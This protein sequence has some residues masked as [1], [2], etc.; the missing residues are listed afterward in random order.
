[1]E[2]ATPFKEVIE[3]IKEN[4]GEA[5]K[6]CYQCG[7]CDTVCPWNRVRTF[8]MRK[9]IREAAFGLTEIE[10]EEIW[11]CTT[12]GKCAQRCPR[13][14]KQIQNMV[15]LRRMATG[16]GVFPGAVKPVR[17]ASAG[18][19]GEGNPFG[20]ERAKRAD[21]A[22]GLPV[23]TF[24]EGMEVLYFPG[25]YLSYDP[26]LKKVAQATANIL[27]KA[28]VDFGILGAGENCCGESI[29]KTG[30][31]ELFKRL[32]R[33]N[34]KT[35]I[36]NGVKKI[37][38]SSPH[39]YHTFKNEYPEFRVNFE[40]I[41]ISQYLFELINEGRLKIS[42]EYGKKVTYHDPCYL[43]RHN[44]IYDEPRGVLKKIPGLELIELAESREESLCCGMGGGRIWMETPKTERFSN[45]RLEEAVGFG[46]EELVTA[47]P[48]CIT[49]FED[50]RVVLNYD[51]VIQVKDITEVLQ[52]VI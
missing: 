6:F 15:A 19:T 37:L 1:M 18:L 25:C 14:V 24:A 16:Y 23:K 51:E 48:Y 40:V 38:V 20:E 44:G 4:G 41:H 26:R 29:R 3:E 35:F 8:S 21:W 13:D 5:V 47:C 39:C 27:N 52:E 49:N 43:G 28:G 50:S 10:H 12:C 31:E 11:R 45:L 42:K 34:I 17:T 46:A 22:K 30:N 9:L 36:E 33:D 7:K 2:T 32:A